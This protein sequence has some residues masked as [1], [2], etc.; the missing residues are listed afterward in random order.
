MTNRRDFFKTTSL[1]VAGSVIGANL[2]TAAT[3]AG[4]KKKKGRTS[5]LFPP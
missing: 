4:K 3:P 1:L 5:A 2:V